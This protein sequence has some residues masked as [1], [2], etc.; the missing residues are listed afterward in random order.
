MRALNFA[1]VTVKGTL[2]CRK[3]EENSRELDVEF[4]YHIH[5]PGNEG[6]SPLIV[7]SFKV[8]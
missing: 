5:H 2:H 4:Q 8:C 1:G 3:S 7:Q 6:D